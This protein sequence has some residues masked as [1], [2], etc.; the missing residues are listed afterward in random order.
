MDIQGSYYKVQ[1]SMMPVG[2]ILGTHCRHLKMCYKERVESVRDGE[3]LM[4]QKMCCPLQ[5]PLD[6]MLVAQGGMGNLKELESVS[7]RGS[8]SSFL[9]L[10]LMGILEIM[11]E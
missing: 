11:A 3:A 2:Y 6:K 9:P 4:R 8:C 7:K 5:I 1:L 10:S